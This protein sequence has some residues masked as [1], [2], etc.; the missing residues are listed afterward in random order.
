MPT[1]WMTYRFPDGMIPNMVVRSNIDV[2]VP[3]PQKI[4]HSFGV[5]EDTFDAKVPNQGGENK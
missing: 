2:D 1:V 3:S 4:L 5:Q